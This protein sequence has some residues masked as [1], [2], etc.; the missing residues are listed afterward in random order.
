MKRLDFVIEQDDGR[1]LRITRMVWLLLEV[2]EAKRRQ[3][4]SSLIYVMN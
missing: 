3:K 1:K 2:R 4:L